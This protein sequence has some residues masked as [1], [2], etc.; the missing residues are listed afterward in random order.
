VRL[1]RLFE[2]R[3]PCRQEDP[4]KMLYSMR[5]DNNNRS[6][7]IPLV[8]KESTAPAKKSAKRATM[9]VSTQTNCAE[10]CQTIPANK[11]EKYSYRNNSADP[12]KQPRWN[13]RQTFPGRETPGAVGST[14]YQP[15][16]F[17]Q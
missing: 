14:K 4:P 12:E 1:G 10:N 15:A 7:E 2:V 6:V 5:R 11:K 17:G 8:P 16:L 9:V 3:R 13:K